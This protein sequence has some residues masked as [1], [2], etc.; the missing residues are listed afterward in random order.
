VQ[1]SP[2]IVSAGGELV[3][4]LVVDGR[5]MGSFG[6]GIQQARGY[7]WQSVSDSWVRLSFRTEVGFALAFQLVEVESSFGSG[8]PHVVPPA[9]PRGRAGAGRG[10]WEFVW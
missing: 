5:M 9:G 10:G 3:W 8:L 6:V 7:V 1:G 2:G 4:Q